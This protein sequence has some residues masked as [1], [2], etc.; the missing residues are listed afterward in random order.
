MATAVVWYVS[1]V[2]FAVLIIGIT[3]TIGLTIP[4]TMIP[5]TMVL[6]IMDGTVPITDLGI[7]TDGMVGTIPGTVGDGDTILIGMVITGTAI[8]GAAIMAAM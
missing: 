8:T 1:T 5:G 4:S 7:A 6:A 2:V 3:I